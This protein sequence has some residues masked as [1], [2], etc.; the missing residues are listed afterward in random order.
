MS[1]GEGGVPFSNVDDVA[2]LRICL[3]CMSLRSLGPCDRISNAVKPFALGAFAS[4]LVWA[5]RN[6]M[7][8]EKFQL[9]NDNRSLFMTQCNAYKLMHKMMYW[10]FAFWVLTLWLVPN[11]S[12]L[13]KFSVIGY[14]FGPLRQSTL[15][16]R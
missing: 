14:Q 11:L 4:I 16:D 7:I 5:T 12:L 10:S 6:L 8:C 13:P 9:I 2:L 3:I 1:K 15:V